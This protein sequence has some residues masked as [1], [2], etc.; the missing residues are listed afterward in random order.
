MPSTNMHPI[1]CQWFLV[2]VDKFPFGQHILSLL[3]PHKRILT[4]KNQQF[5]TAGKFLIWG[6]NTPL[7]H[8][9]QMELDHLWQIFDSAS[10]SSATK[11]KP[12]N[13]KNNVFLGAFKETKKTLTRACVKFENKSHRTSHFGVGTFFY[14]K[15]LFF[16]VWCCTQI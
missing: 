12:T 1:L 14:R 15:S 6:I 8:W 4:L 16:L 10:K 7:C 2:L 13:K 11:A 9:S 5:C 3:L